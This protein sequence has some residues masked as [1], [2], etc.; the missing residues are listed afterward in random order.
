MSLGSE[1]ISKIFQGWNQPGQ[2]EYNARRT[3]RM[4]ITVMLYATGITKGV[5]GNGRRWKKLHGSLRIKLARI[6]PS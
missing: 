6:Q 2:S 4:M 5:T 1:P 3:G